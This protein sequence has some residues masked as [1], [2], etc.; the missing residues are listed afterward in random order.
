MNP[1]SPPRPERLELICFAA[2]G[3]VA[4]LQWASLV[5]D[6]PAVRVALA[7]VLATAAGARTR[8][9]RPAPPPPHDPLGRSARGRHRRASWRD[10]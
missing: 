2:L 8:G 9:D 6:P 4:A 10:W 3:I 1:L 5:A 7:V